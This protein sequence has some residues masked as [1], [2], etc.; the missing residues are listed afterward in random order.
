[1]SYGIVCSAC[2]IW[3]YSIEKQKEIEML[4]REKKGELYYSLYS[5][6]VMVVFYRY[7]QSISRETK[8]NREVDQRER[9]WVIEM[10]VVHT[11]YKVNTVDKTI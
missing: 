8:R 4:T 3:L 11:I 5:T 1:M 10:L 9:R 2:N 6:Y 7:W